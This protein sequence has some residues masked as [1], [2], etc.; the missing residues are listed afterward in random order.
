M[1]LKTYKISDEQEKILQDMKD[2]MEKIL[3]EKRD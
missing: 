1:F 3:D 2:W